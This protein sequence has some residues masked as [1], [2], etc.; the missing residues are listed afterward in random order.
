[1]SLQLLLRIPS[2]VRLLIKDQTSTDRSREER[3]SKA[4]ERSSRTV[5]GWL[6]LASWKE[7]R[8]SMQ[9]CGWGSTGVLQLQ[10]AQAPL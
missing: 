7:R 9:L 6:R 3:R 1:M 2:V 8:A 4:D 5:G 10:M